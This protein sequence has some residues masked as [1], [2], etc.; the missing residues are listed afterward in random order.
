MLEGALWFLLKVNWDV[1]KIGVI[2]W[3]PHE[4]QSE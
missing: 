1:E 3:W 4:F 2:G